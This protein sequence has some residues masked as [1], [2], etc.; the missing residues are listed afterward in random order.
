MTAAEQEE[1]ASPAPRPPEPSR[2]F[3]Q[4]AGRTGLEWGTTLVL[5]ALV[6][7]GIGIL[8]APDLPEQAPGFTLPDLQNQPVSLSDFSGQKVVLNF[9]ATWC[10]PCQQIAPKYK[11]LAAAL[12]H[13]KFLKV[14]PRRFLDTS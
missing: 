13:V 6:W 3:W 8:R 4:R 14:L 2:S 9:W 10:G 1:A 5:I 11:E 7:V 12:P